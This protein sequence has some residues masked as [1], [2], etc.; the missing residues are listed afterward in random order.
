MKKVPIGLVVLAFAA[1][2]FAQNAQAVLDSAQNAMGITTMTSM[3]LVANG[4]L[5]DT[6]EAAGGNA[7]RP[8]VKTYEAD[9]HFGTPAMRL[10]IH[11]TNPDGTRLFYGSLQ[12]QFV[13]GNYAW[14]LWNTEDAP[15]PARGGPP[16]GAGGPPGAPPGAGGPPGLPPAG[17]PVAGGGPPAGAGPPGAGAPARAGG[18]GG[19]G[20]AAGPGAGRGGPTIRESSVAATRRTQILLT[21]PGF[22][23]AALQNNAAVTTQGA[24]RL[25]TFTAQGQQ[26]VGAL[27]A[28]NVL[29]KITTTNPA[30]NNVPVETTFTMYRSF[31]G[32]RFPSRIVQTEGGVE[33][34][35]LT[36]TDVKANQAIAVT[37]PANVQQPQAPAARGN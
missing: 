10:L 28:M 13:S 5:A 23:K 19:P 14:D 35:K 31:G 22:I 15:A 25:I 30:R 32:V 37:V 12:V 26:Y 4:T 24:S 18:P 16:P 20:G 36:V 3:Y 2:A 33:V 6:G 17:G 9:V 29:T 21:P 1:S 8:I 34:L 7:P 11:R 27:N